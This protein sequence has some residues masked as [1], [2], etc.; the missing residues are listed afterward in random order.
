M[1]LRPYLLASLLLLLLLAGCGG[2][3]TQ[4]IMLKL[5]A[6]GFHQDQVQVEAGQPVTLRLVN[7]DGYA[8]AFD[9]DEFDIHLPLA[10][11]ETSDLTFTPTQTGTFTF[12]C[13]APGHEAAGMIGSLTVLP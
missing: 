11:K 12:Y 10:A 6:M 5:E 1:K 3:K 13:G 8:H 7:K 4:E 9:M 2:A